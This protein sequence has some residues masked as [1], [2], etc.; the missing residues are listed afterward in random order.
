MM[1]H[2]PPAP[3]RYHIPAQF[4]AP[5]RGAYQERSAG[6]PILVS[7]RLRLPGDL[8]DSLPTLVSSFAPLRPA[9]AG[10]GGAAALTQ[11]L[12]PASAT[13]AA[14]TALPRR[15]WSDQQEPLRAATII[16]GT[17]LA[18]TLCSAAILGQQWLS[19]ATG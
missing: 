7:P 3:G 10:R 11:A 4:Q 13:V 14:A 9:A 8:P 16:F 18:G 5:A 2:A 1:F 15:P 17:I 6:G 19:V 12:E